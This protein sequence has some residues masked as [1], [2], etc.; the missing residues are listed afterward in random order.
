MRIC[1]LRGVT[2]GLIDG[3]V[4]GGEVWAARRLLLCLRKVDAVLNCEESVLKLRYLRNKGYLRI[5]T[6]LFA[7]YA[8]VLWKT[9]RIKYLANHQAPAST[10]QASRG[11]NR[12]YR[13]QSNPLILQHQF[14]QM[15]VRSFDPSISICY[16]HCTTLIFCCNNRKGL[17]LRIQKPLAFCITRKPDSQRIHCHYRIILSALSYSPLSFKSLIKGFSNKHLA[18]SLHHK[19]RSC[20]PYKLHY[21]LSHPPPSPPVEKSCHNSIPPHTPSQSML[22]PCRVLHT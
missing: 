7:L 5:Q 16:I 20:L 9:R 19:A 6:W 10:T 18:D 4:E 22:I 8:V 3:T 1:N 11:G 13:C 17:N 21:T 12:S 15:A 14:V 2:I